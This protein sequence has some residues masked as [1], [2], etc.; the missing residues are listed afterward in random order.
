MYVVGIYVT[1]GVTDRGTEGGGRGAFM[2]SSILE[3]EEIT[4]ADFIVDYRQKRNS[5]VFVIIFHI[6]Y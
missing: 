6:Y 2:P 1:H 4:F 5:L 3:D